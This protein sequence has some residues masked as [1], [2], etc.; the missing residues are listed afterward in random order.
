MKPNSTVR[1]RY[2]QDGAVPELAGSWW[3]VPATVVDKAGWVEQTFLENAAAA[4][5]A[6]AKAER[7]AQVLRDRIDA[8]REEETAVARL[9]AELAELRAMVEA[10]PSPEGLMDTTA[11]LASASAAIAGTIAQYQELSRQ[12]QDLE[13]VASTQLT[14]NQQLL[15]QSEA[16]A[17]E[18]MAQRD[19]AIEIAKNLQIQLQ[20]TFS[21][22]G[23]ALAKLQAGLNDTDE[24]VAELNA[25]ATRHRQTIE[26]AAGI[27][28]EVVEIAAR[29][30]NAVAERSADEMRTFFSILLMSLGITRSDLDRSLNNLDQGLDRSAFVV[31]RRYIASAVQIAESWAK[32]SPLG[33][34]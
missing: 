34:V 28:Q 19:A 21:S 11:S 12:L 3:D 20:G 24:L 8:Q 32:A 1:V 23:A 7:E 25:S 18:A 30:A 4:A 13:A 15:E 26:R 6:Q 5:A 14:E 33:E 22:Y 27:E 31:S 9:E 16:F 17:V 10:Q 2:P 29:E